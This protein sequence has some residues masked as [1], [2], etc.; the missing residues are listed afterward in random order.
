MANAAT[1][2]TVTNGRGLTAYAATVALATAYQESKLRNIHV[3]V[4]HD[5]LGLFQ[6]RVLYYTAAVAADPVKATNTFLDGLVSQPDWQTRPLTQV[7]ADIQRPDPRYRGRYAQWQPLAAQLT[8]SCGPGPPPAR[9]ATLGPPA[10]DCGGDGRSP[11]AR[12]QP[13]PPDPAG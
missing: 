9:A 7:A 3:A 13:Q 11:P 10:P 12:T 6:Q 1:I 2:V 4:N 5:S 8:A